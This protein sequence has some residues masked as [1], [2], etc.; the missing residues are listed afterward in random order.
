MRPL[1]TSLAILFLY[2]SLSASVVITNG[3]S[4]AHDM[5]NLQSVKGVV[6]IK[7]IG[8]EPQRIIIYKMDQTMDCVG[9][10]SFMDADSLSRSNASWI[11]LSAVEEV[12]DTG[13]MF[14]L[15]YEIQKPSDSNIKG[16]YWSMIMVE[17]I[18]D[19]EA[20]PEK[21]GITVRSNLRYAVQIISNVGE[22]ESY[23]MEFDSV[24]YD[25][26][27]QTLEMM[28]SNPTISIMRP[29]FEVKLYSDSGHT[30]NV[31]RE[32]I[33]K[34]YPGTCRRISIPI[35]DIQQGSYDGVVIAKTEGQG[36][37]GYNVS[38]EHSP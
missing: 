37:Y 36:V 32:N 11:N 31:K 35:E 29:Y 4:H 30:V 24:F 28:I 7:N 5:T 14:E 16:S 8:K 6:K 10:G 22:A 27:N 33:V 26:E 3:L 25:L 17:N 38:I 9:G 13:Q 34:L 2:T 20:E 23:D 12:L 18:P 1:L 21:K 19:I 15:V